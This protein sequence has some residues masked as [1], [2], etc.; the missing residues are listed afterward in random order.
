MP[1]YGDP[2]D[3]APGPETSAEEPGRGFDAADRRVLAIDLAAG[4]IDP[5]MRPPPRACVFARFRQ[6]TSDFLSLV[7]PD[8]IVA[9]L[10]GPDFD[11]LDLAERLAAYGFAGR[12]LALTTPL[13]CPEAVRAE[14]CSHAGRLSF[15]LVFLSDD[16]EA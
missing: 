11:V 3:T 6:L 13:P 4:Q 2:T 12:L 8:I 14:V 5:L 1:Q 16:P 7:A 9:P 10:F 15:D